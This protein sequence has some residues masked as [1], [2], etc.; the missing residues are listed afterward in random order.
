MKSIQKLGIFNKH[1]RLKKA[2]KQSGVV[3]ARY[4]IT[5]D[6]LK[7]LYIPLLCMPYKKGNAFEGLLVHIL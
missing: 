5:P 2:P 6:K 4:L 3:H 1:S 7:L